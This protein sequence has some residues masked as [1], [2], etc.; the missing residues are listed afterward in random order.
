M[1]TTTAQ[2][3]Y[4]TNP[5]TGRI[6]CVSD[7]PATCCAGYT[8]MAAYRTSSDGQAWFGHDGGIYVRLAT[9]DAEDFGAAF[10]AVC[11]CDLDARRG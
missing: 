8:L 4:L 11:D 5:V 3:T 10:G 6:V 2:K 7:D 1:A 9:E